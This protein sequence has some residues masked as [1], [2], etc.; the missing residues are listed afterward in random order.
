MNYT[1][2]LKRAWHILWHY[3]ALW[4]FG[5]LLALTGSG[6]GGGGA[7]GQGSVNF[8]GNGRNFNNMPDSEFFRQLENYFDKMTFRFENL[9]FSDI[10]PWIVLGGLVVLVLMV[11]FTVLRNLALTAN[12]KM[13]DH[14]E[15][16]GEKV[17]WKQGFRWGWSKKIWQL[18]LIDLVVG[19]PVAAIV[20]ILLGC[21]GLPF[22]FGIPAN[23]AATAVGIIAGIGLLLLA[24]LIIAVIGVFIGV[25]LK[26]A[27]RVCVLDEKGVIDSLSSGW[28][29]MRGY[30]KDVL[31]LWLIMVGVQI[32]VGLVMIP[33]VLIILL[34]SGLAGGGIGFVVWALSQGAIA[35]IV[36]GFIIF[37]VVIILPSTFVGGLGETYYETVWTLLFRETKLPK[38]ISDLSDLP[39]DEPQL[40]EPA[41][42]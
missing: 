34:I 14:Y 21:A 11:V 22:L 17:S 41:L 30:W 1:N 25:W 35:A 37:M 18:F 23:N 3:P 29:L 10:L 32:A 19:L 9:Q 26:L 24:I 33:V 13:V 27:K 31:I 42:A 5:F 4:V 2:F 15:V 39:G 20:L 16:T 40:V 36:T 7:G 38:D 8:D 12:Y 28:R 6:G